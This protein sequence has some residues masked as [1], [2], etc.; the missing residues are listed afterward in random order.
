MTHH[1]LIKETLE[2]LSNVCLGV[3]EECK[4]YSDED[5][6]NAV[7]VFQEVFMGKMFEFHKDK[8]LSVKQ[9]EAIAMAAG[10]SLRSKL[11]IYTG[12]DPHKLLK[13]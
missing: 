6:L 13:K 5:L 11:I 1:E 10:K 12:K 7:I 4:E 3:S 8:G 9:M 2:K